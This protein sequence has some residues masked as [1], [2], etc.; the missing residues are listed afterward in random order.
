MST[1]E[2]VEEKKVRLSTPDDWTLIEHI[3]RMQSVNPLRSIKELVDNA[4]DAFARD[5]TY[6]PSDGKTVKV[7]IGK[8]GTS[9]YIKTVDNAL[10]WECNVTSGMPNFEYSVKHIGDSIKKYLKEYQ[11]ARDEG[12]AIGQYALGLLSFWALGNRL[13]VLSR[14]RLPNGKVGNCSRMVWIRYNPEAAITDNVELPPELSRSSGCVVIVDELEKARMGLVTGMSLQKYLARSCRTRL[15]KTDVNLKVH[16]QGKKFIVKPM[17]YEGTQFPVDKCPI[18]GGFGSIELEI[19]LFPP[20][21]EPDEYKVPIFARG[22]KVYDDITQIEE[23]DIYPWNSKKVYGQIDYPWGTVSPS[24]NAFV[25]DGF[26]EAFIA[27]M[28]EIT[29]K[30]SKQIEEIEARRRKWQRKKF[31]E[32]FERTWQEILSK[33]PEEWHRKKEGPIKKPEK[34]EEKKKVEPGPMYR[35]E[36]SPQDTQV[37]CDSVQSFTAKAFDMNENPVTDPN[38]IY[39]WKV[40]PV[41]VGLLTRDQY[42]TCIFKAGKK[43]GAIATITATVFQYLEESGKEKTVAKTA[44]TNIWIVSQISKK[45]PS[46]PRGDKPPM[47]DEYPL[48]NEIHS[49]FVPSMNMVQVNNQHRD[50]KAAAEQ[51]DEAL[52]RYI[53]Y[54]YCKEI[55][56]DRWKDLTSDPHELSE[57]IADLLAI[58]DL[59]FDWKRLAQKRRGRPQRR[60]ET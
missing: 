21:V 3:G 39:Y 12:T 2:R 49:K 9:E 31:Y 36:I 40:E 26:F 16:Y 43:E 54:C 24:R 53:N 7:E 33:L 6:S 15:M 55:A 10:G 47:Y 23:L 57:K 46:A 38:M 32:A 11:K 28:K 52:Y 42:Q 41:G 27:T 58:S 59:A 48:G 22:A 18:K 20:S 13:T 5:P 4:I 29:E 51:G 14:C 19:Y 60:E 45:P 35:L 56:V 25:I 34:E 44:S 50:F 37:Q 1:Q 17:K 30:L 8:S